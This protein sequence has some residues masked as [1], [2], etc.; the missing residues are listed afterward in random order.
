MEQI[1][2]K[3][4]A[5]INLG[6][7]I[8]KKREDGYHEV[9]M[10]MQTLNLFDIITI[11]KNPS[12]SPTT[13]LL[14]GGISIT[15][16]CSTLPCDEH[17]LVYKA[18]KL[19]K[20]EFQIA[21]NIHIHIEKNIPIAAGMAGGSTDCAST[22]LGINQ[23]FQLGLS[24]QQ[25]QDRGVTLGADVPYCIM[26]GT[27]LSEGIGEILT[28][29]PNTPNCF[30]IVIKPGISISTKWVYEH[31]CLKDVI[32]HPDIDGIVKGLQDNNLPAILKRF[33]NV[34]ETVTIPLHPIIAKLK[35]TLIT[36]GADKALM[37]GSGPT[38]FGLFQSERVANSAFDHC[39]KIYSDMDIFLTTFFQP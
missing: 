1:K 38:V 23:L 20:Q 30:C 17:N 16:S 11:I 35:Q 25:L 12:F 7:D 26:Q 10:I 28:P 13:T 3:A 14:E 36:E 32:N 15:T 21:N 6:L 29:L 33:D 22:L 37:S 31:F 18:A 24:H 2:I 4:P 27:A 8:L 5:K 9:R 39:K 34:L 19:L